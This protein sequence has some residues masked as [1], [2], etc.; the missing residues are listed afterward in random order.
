MAWALLA[1]AL[2]GAST[3]ASKVL[4][5]SLG[6][7]GLAG[8]LY[9]GAGIGALAAQLLTARQGARWL[10]VG[11]RNRIR[12]LGAVFFGGAVGPVLLLYGLQSAPAA[13]VAIW[14]NLET[15]ATALLA[16][17]L[18]REHLGRLS[19]LANGGVFLAGVLLSLGS[20]WGGLLPALLVGAACV[21]WGMDNNLT[22]IIDDLTPNQITFWK[23]AVAGGTNLA[24]GLALEGQAPIT[25]VVGALVLGALSYGASISLY[26]AAAQRL[27][28]S[29]SQMLF[30]SA[31]F[32]GVA[33][34]LIFLREPLTPWQVAALVILVASLRLLFSEEHSHKH[35]HEPQ[36]HVHI[37]DHAEDHHQH[38]AA[39][40]AGDDPEWHEHAP[41]VHEHSHLPDL[42]HRH[43]HD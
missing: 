35:G 15:V 10:P 36:A 19:W 1:A 13:S 32:F 5:G 6:P 17:L 31:P 39:S 24:I 20:G 37:H 41:V 30:S 38:G 21:A 27:G 29:R 14:L 18:F 23:G 34:S 11:H 8:L 9:L 40:I 16:V 3:P 43:D 12:L 2:F 25:F 7:F 33:L 42:H 4:L 22:A 26:I 28:A